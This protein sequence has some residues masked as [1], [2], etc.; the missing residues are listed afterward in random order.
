MMLSS[1][2]MSVL[3]SM[4]S[5]GTHQHF[6]LLS[7]KYMFDILV[8]L[9]PTLKMTVAPVVKLLFIL[10]SNYINDLNTKK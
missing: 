7:N 5:L 2:C 4:D 8:F 6:F 1:F 10:L 9:F 3:Y